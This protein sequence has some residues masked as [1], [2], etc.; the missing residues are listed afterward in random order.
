MNRYYQKFVDD[1]PSAC[2]A[3][4]GYIEENDLDVQT[5]REYLAIDELFKDVVFTSND[6]ILFYSGSFAPFHAGHLAALQKSLDRAIFQ[7]F[8]PFKV[9][10]SCAHDNYVDKK[11][12]QIFKYNFLI[13]NNVINSFIQ[14]EGSELLRS[15]YCMHNYEAFLTGPVNPF[16]LLECLVDRFSGTGASVGFIFGSDM[17]LYKNII[18]YVNDA[19]LFMVPRPG[20]PTSEFDHKGGN[21]LICSPGLNMSSTEYRELF[22]D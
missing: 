10:V 15:V 5:Y 20:Y 19:I 11:T 16:T 18:K 6:L 1:N 22:P 7:G 14:T 4:N 13:R 9:L 2:L 3:C 12:K 17:V 21:L 8:N